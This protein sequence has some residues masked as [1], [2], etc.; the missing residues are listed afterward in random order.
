SKQE[1]GVFRYGA[2][3]VH[4][5]IDDFFDY[6][7]ALVGT[8]ISLG[9]GRSVAVAAPLHLLLVLVGLVLA[10]MG[11]MVDHTHL[12]PVTDFPPPMLGAGQRLLVVAGTGLEAY[13]PLL[14]LAPLLRTWLERRELRIAVMVIIVLLVIV[15]ALLRWALGGPMLLAGPV[16]VAL[17][18]V[19]MPRPPKKRRRSAIASVP[20]FAREI[21]LPEPALDP[22]SLP[23]NLSPRPPGAPGGDRKGPPRGRV[24]GIGASG[25]SSRRGRDV[26]D[27]ISSPMPASTS[28]GSTGLPPLPSTPEVTAEALADPAKVRLRLLLI[29]VGGVL[30][31]AILLFFAMRLPQVPYN[32]RE[33]FG[34]GGGYR[35]LSF[36]LFLIA[37]ATLPALAGQWLAG[38]RAIVLLALPLLYLAIWLPIWILLEKTVTSESLNDILGSSKLGWPVFLERSF[39]FS[40][41][42][43]PLMLIPMAWSYWLASNRLLGLGEGSKRLG[44]MLLA[45]LPLFYYGQWVVVDQA[46]TDNVVELLY[47]EGSWVALLGAGTTIA[48][49]AGHG[50]LLGCGFGCGLWG[51]AA[52]VLGLPLLLVAGWFAINTGLTQQGVNFMLSANRESTPS[53]AELIVRWSIFQV[54]AA[55]LLGVGWRL[56][57]AWFSTLPAS[58]P[59]ARVPARRAPPWAE[60]L[61][62]ASL[63]LALLGTGLLAGSATVPLNSLLNRMDAG[64]SRHAQPVRAHVFEGRIRHLHPRI[65]F[66]SLA[67]WD[68][69][70]VPP[71]FEGRARRAQE[72]KR[73]FRDPCEHSNLEFDIACWLTSGDLERGAQALERLRKVKPELPDGGNQYGNG[74]RL[75]FAYDL[76]SLHPD[77]DPATV[78][79]VQRKLEKLLDAYLAVLGESGPSLWHGRTTLAGNAW[80]VALALEPGRAGYQR[81]VTEAQRH[82]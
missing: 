70:G 46:V 30:A 11:W 58:V 33:L 59:D 18:W 21:Q 82:F 42:A 15:L 72:L 32:V 38:K 51:M 57:H 77:M 22:D 48:L 19:L 80:L 20:S 35:Y 1:I 47:R 52:I 65:L 36:P 81:R 43:V 16:A 41:F 53:I 67:N 9:V 68:G 69:H 75:A 45:A 3:P 54:G 34:G 17:G 8:A 66:P 29:A 56:A 49:I 24:G 61:A 23:T 28:R 62:A 7:L 71:L 12:N 60:P 14:M 31:I 50:I 40:G 6:I 27:T 73:P 39:R 25:A 78:D 64:V 79:Q 55:A 5:E 37:A 44:L 76:L 63:M 4:K 26:D 2:E 74:G 13:V 10:A